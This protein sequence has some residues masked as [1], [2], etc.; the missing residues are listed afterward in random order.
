MPD[1][2]LE[3]RESDG[4]TVVTRSRAVSI[5]S[6]RAVDEGGRLAVVVPA[7]EPASTAFTTGRYV[8][9]FNGGATINV[10]LVNE[11]PELNFVGGGP[12]LQCSMFD[13]FADLYR[14]TAEDS[15]WLNTA[16]Q[17]V[18][19]TAAGTPPGLLYSTGW[20]L[21]I[22]AAVGTALVTQEAQG[23]TLADV[24][25]KSVEDLE[26]G[27]TPVHW[28]ADAVT[29]T[30]HVGFLGSAS[31]VRL[32]NPDAPDPAGALPTVTIADLTEKGTG[33]LINRLDP[34]GGTAG[35]QTRLQL[36]GTESGQAYLPQVRTS[37][38]GGTIHYIQDAASTAAYGLWAAEYSDNTADPGNMTGG[39]A[40]DLLYKGSCAHLAR[41]KDPHLAWQVEAAGTAL[42]AIDPGE[43]CAVWYHR[44][45]VNVLETGATVTATQHIDA[46]GYV[47]K[48]TRR[49]DR[50]GE[51]FSLELGS[52]LDHKIGSSDAEKIGKAVASAAHA[53][54]SRSVGRV[55][56]AGGLPASGAA[57]ANATY[58]TIAAESSLSAET[59]HAAVGTADRHNP[60]AHTHAGTADAFGGALGTALFDLPTLD[61]QIRDGGTA[62]ATESAWVKVTV[63]DASGFLRVYA[64]E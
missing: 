45:Y 23:E 26:V 59:T 43:S 37:R 42:R 31:G 28:W 2:L 21:D 57:P 39:Q 41:R 19:G 54:G 64:T 11:P 7:N 63:G 8:Y 3:V 10:G 55:V 46:T 61:L 29:R 18:L 50:E 1:L 53:A 36:W 25:K 32:A 24:I 4:T 58:V 27:G 33:E 38:M 60:K 56:T 9:A 40:R 17:T 44:R 30:L 51:R 47:T 12:T 52:T 5:E 35:G 14:T 48:T 49:I 15:M 62:G 13:R 34:Y 20:T 22:A 6:V 16:I